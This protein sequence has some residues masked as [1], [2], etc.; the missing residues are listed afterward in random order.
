M[1]PSRSTTNNS[2]EQFSKQ[3]YKWNLWIDYV[4]NDASY[5]HVKKI[6]SGLNKQ[7]QT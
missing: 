6:L 5:L 2:F 3:G 7:Q 4:Q 1:N